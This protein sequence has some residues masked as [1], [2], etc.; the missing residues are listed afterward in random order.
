MSRLGL[1]WVRLQHARVPMLVDPP[2]FE[3]LPAN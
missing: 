2:F 3:F 1:L